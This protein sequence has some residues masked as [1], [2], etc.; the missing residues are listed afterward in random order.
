MKGEK[1]CDFS[2]IKNLRSKLSFIPHFSS[3]TY[4]SFT[5]YHSSFFIWRYSMYLQQDDQDDH[6]VCVCAGAQVA[7]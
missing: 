1:S 3:L 2:A 5:I 4:S 7:P 6:V